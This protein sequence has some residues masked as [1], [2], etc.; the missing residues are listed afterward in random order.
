MKA[1]DLLKKQHKEVKAL[2]KKVEKT[3]NARERRQL[4]EE[5]SQQLEVHT[6]IEEEI[7]YPAVRESG[8][9]AEEMVDEAY[10]EHHVVKLVLKELPQVDPEDERFDAKMTVLSELVEHHAEEEEDEMFK[11]AEKALGK[12]RLNELGEE[13]AQRAGAPRGRRAA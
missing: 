4:M 9:K 2:F 13:M 1:T 8:K 10:E 7:F 3:E 6:Q 12:E 5:I 11:I